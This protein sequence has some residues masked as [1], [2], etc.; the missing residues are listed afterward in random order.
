MSTEEEQG[1]GEG[2]EHHSHKHSWLLQAFQEPEHDQQRR[3][4]RAPLLTVCI[5]FDCP[6]RFGLGSLKVKGEEGPIPQ[7]VR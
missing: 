4:A 6:H 2:G 5:R 7:Q 1:E 3:E